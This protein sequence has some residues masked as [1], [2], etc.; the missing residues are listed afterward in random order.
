MSYM[1][2]IIYE[3]CSMS[4]QKSELG[5]RDFYQILRIVHAHAS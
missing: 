2:D 1:H 5:L 3:P 4:I